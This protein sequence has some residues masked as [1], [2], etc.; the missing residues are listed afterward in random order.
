[1]IAAL[2]NHQ[3]A[4]RLLTAFKDQIT[5]SPAA[6]RQ[7]ERQGWSARLCRSK[8]RAFAAETIGWLSLEEAGFF[9]EQG[10]NWAQLQRAY[11]I[12]DDSPLSDRLRGQ[13]AI[14]I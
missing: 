9:E 10:S 12:I 2:V 3:D 1:M 8:V 13:V 5:D 4:P 6:V 11:Q 14:S 7:F